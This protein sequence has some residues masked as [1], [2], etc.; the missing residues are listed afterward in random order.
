MDCDPPRGI[1]QPTACPAVPS[2]SAKAEDAGD[3]NGRKEC[4][5]IPANK[6]G[7]DSFLN[8]IFVNNVAGQIAGIPNRARANGCRGKCSIGWR[9]SAASFSQSRV[10][11]FINL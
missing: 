7:A 11:G 6:A 1:G 10:S 4:A 2:T 8:K 5:A 9:N 3:S